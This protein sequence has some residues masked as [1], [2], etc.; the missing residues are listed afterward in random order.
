MSNQYTESYYKSSNYSNY[1]EREDRYFKLAKEI[2]H[3]LESIGLINSNT[4][5]VDFG[6]AVGHLIKGIKRC[7]Y[8]NVVG[9]ELSDWA[10]NVCQEKELTTHKNINDVKF[11]EYL[12]FGLDVFEH[13]N[14]FSLDQ[15]MNTAKTQIIVGRIPVAIEGENNFYLEISRK[16]PT[17]INCK[18]KKEWI[19][20]FKNNKFNTILKLNL[21]TIL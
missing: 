14:D 7:G 8:T 4:N 9:V 12:L 13:M 1:L 19:T 20:F 5:I 11:N 16:D 18:T 2:T 6:C 17:H 15:L 21:N 3:T 10:R